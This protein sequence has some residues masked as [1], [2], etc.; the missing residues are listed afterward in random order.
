MYNQER[1]TLSA[2]SIADAKL[3][4]NPKAVCECQILHEKV[5]CSYLEKDTKNSYL[6]WCLEVDLHRMVHIS[7]EKPAEARSPYKI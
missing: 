3:R 6:Q 5:E 4:T 1:I 2:F 7:R